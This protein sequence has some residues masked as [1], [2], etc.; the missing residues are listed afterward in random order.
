MKTQIQ[1]MVALLK[2]LLPVTVRLKIF[3]LN[4][5]FNYWAAQKTNEVKCPICG[6]TEAKIF[7]F[8][9]DKTVTGKS[10]SYLEISAGHNKYCCTKCGNVYATWLQRDVTEVGAIYAGICD[11]DSEVNTENERKETQK[12]MMRIVVQH[13]NQAEKAAPRKIK[14]LDFGCGPN[15]KAAQE[16]ESECNVLEAYCCDVNPGLPYA[17]EKFFRFSGKFPRE[18][19]GEF[20]GMASVDVFE[21]LNYPIQDFTEFNRLL[22]MDGIMVHFAPLQ[23]FLRLRRGHYET[24]FHVNFPSEKAMRILCEKTG[25]EYLGASM[26]RYGYWYAAFRKVATV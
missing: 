4:F 22:K 1:K 18:M 9:P 8:G 7:H 13:L 3:R 15:Y 26:P 12:E 6:N 17:G 19:Y 23:Q 14:I 11:E 24:A 16:I 21:H 25:F 20:D 5:L 10:I 2:P